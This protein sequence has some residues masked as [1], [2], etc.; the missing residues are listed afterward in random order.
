M[1][2]NCC[3]VCSGTS[4]GV[5]HTSGSGN[6]SL[7]RYVDRYENCT[8]VDGN[9][10]ITFLEHGPYNLSFLSSIQEVQCCDGRRLQILGTH[11]VLTLLK[12]RQINC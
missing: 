2:W 6:W 11:F 9:L 1:I 3:A 5:S 7:S 4:S 8:F 10:E 12:K